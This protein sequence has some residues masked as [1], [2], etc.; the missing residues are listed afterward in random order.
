[1]LHGHNTDTWIAFEADKQFTDTPTDKISP[2][3]SDAITKGDMKVCQSLI[4][5]GFS[6]DGTCECGCT[7]LLKALVQRQK[8]V[9]KYLLKMGASVDGV[10]CSKEGL[11]SGLSLLHLASLEGDLETLQVVLRQSSVSN[12]FKIQPIHLAARNGSPEILRFL[13]E[14]A[15]DKTSLLEAKTP[16]RADYSNFEGFRNLLE[17]AGQAGPLHIAVRFVR[18]EAA[19]YLLRAGADLEAR[20]ERGQTAMHIGVSI[21][22]DKEVLELLIKAGAC[23]N[24]R[25]YEGRTPLMIA[26]ESN[27][28]GLV[29]D[30]MALVPGR[31]WGR[32]I[33]LF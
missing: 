16:K 26:L 14:C 2:A 4:G 13:V 1:M 11:A 21:R 7:A 17:N 28:Q 31:C 23:L 27:R 20:D 6:F 15:E 9:A 12:T 29:E 10:A 32:V 8:D 22:P 19:E 24:V 30:L 18:V 25:D 33:F 3:L 5:R